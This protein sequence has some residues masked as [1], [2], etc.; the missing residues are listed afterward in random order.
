MYVGL[1]VFAAVILT[2]GKYIHVLTQNMT[3][4]PQIQ[5]REHLLTKVSHGNT[6]FIPAT[7][8]LM[9]WKNLEACLNP[10]T[11]KG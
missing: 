9:F 10:W 5:K 2:D 7:N 3:C 11:T 6:V 4:F 8:F 1:R